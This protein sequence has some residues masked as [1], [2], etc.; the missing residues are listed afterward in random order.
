ML[1]GPGSAPGSARRWRL[2]P[3]QAAAGDRRRDRAPG[4]D[5][6]A[7]GRAAKAAARTYV[8][9]DGVTRR[10]AAAE[11]ERA[12][13]FRGRSCDAIV[14]VG[15]GSV[16]D[17]AKVIAWPPPTASIRASWSAT[18]AACR[19][20]APIYA[21]PTTAGTG[22]EV[23]VAAVVSD[24]E[25]RQASWWSPTRAGAAHGGARP[26]ADDGAAAGGHRRHRHGRADARGGGLHRRLGHAVHRPHGA[27]RR[28]ADLRHL[29]RGLPQGADLAR[30]SRWRWPATYAGLAFTRANV[31]NVH[32][33]AHQLGGKYHTPH[34]LANA[35]LLPHVLRFSLPQAAA[36]AAGPPAR[37][38]GGSGR[39]PSGRCASST[40][41]RR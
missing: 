14:A 33:I 26:G 20:P 38:H 23:T 31:G 15:G 16:M 2:R 32:A 25:A 7:D 30:A 39:R 24:P 41:C 10:R 13:R 6:A 1:V 11:V 37:R 8:V 27:G 9:F 36:G 3:P 29:P 18:S 34:G 40:R 5:A 22:S 35:M 4:A 28:G 19:G 21:V 17:A 12:W